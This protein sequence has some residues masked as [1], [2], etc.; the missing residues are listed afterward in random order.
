MCGKSTNLGT[1]GAII[2][3][4]VVNAFDDPAMKKK[5]TLAVALD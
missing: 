2:I 1:S 5:V 3:D 4:A